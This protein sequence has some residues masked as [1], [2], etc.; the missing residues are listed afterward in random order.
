MHGGRTRS[1]AVTSVAPA[2]LGPPAAVIRAALF[3]G[4]ARRCIRRLPSRRS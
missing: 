1:S 4:M 3:T 2:A